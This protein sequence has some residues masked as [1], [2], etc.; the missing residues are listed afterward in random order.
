MN[1]K[2]PTPYDDSLGHKINKRM[3]HTWVK[4]QLLRLQLI[5]HPASIVDGMNHT[6]DDHDGLLSQ[7]I[8]KN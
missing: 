6:L 2:F 7:T 4:Y 5:Y 3:K 8:N 1:C